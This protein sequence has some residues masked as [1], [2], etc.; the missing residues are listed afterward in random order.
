MPGDWTNVSG[1]AQLF[2]EHAQDGLT[3]RDMMDKAETLVSG[4]T[5]G[6]TDGSD[7][8]CLGCHA[9][10]NGTPGLT[11]ST[12][13]KEHL[14]LGRATEVAWEAASMAQTGTTCGW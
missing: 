10:W 2:L 1:H 14:V 4:A 5:Y 12:A 13:W 3:S 8:V 7:G 11:C 6:T 9:V